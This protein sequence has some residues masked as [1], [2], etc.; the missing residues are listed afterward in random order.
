MPDHNSDGPDKSSRGR[1]SYRRA[2]QQ[3]MEVM[4]MQE[5]VRAAEEKNAKRRKLIGMA[6]EKGKEMDK[7]IKKKKLMVDEDL[8]ES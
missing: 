5:R 6:K 7:E 8:V 1:Q 3:K 2:F 4:D